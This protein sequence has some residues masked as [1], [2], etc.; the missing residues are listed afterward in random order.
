M[1]LRFRH[2]Q[3]PRCPAVALTVCPP[4]CS[5]DVPTSGSP[6]CSTGSPARRRAIVAPVAG[7]TRDSLD[8]LAEWDGVEF[9]LVDTGGLY[10]ASEDPLHAL[11]IEQGRRAIDSADLFVFVVDGREGLVSG[12]QMIAEVLRETGKRVVMAVNKMDDRRA[13]DLALEFYQTGFEPVVE[14]A[15]EHGQGVSDLLDEVVSRIRHVEPRQPQPTRGRSRRRASRLSAGRTSASRPWS[16]GWCE[17]SASWCPTCPGTTRDADR[18]GDPLAQADVPHRRHGGH[19]A[20]RPGRAR[21]AGG[22]R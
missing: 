15:A 20:P 21:G 17:R 12:D 8:Q 7:T 5:W 13:R 6:R 19:P 16:T 14:I 2:H 10:G 9:R 1:N 11:V 18:H 22:S 4:S 3:H